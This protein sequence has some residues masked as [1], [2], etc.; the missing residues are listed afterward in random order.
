MIYTFYADCH[1]GM[2]NAKCKKELPNLTREKVLAT[3]AYYLGDN[4]DLH[5]CKESDLS[6]L[7]QKLLA[8]KVVFKGRYVS[9]NH[10]CQGVSSDYYIFLNDIVFMHGDIAEWGEKRAFEFRNKPIAVK[11]SIWKKLSYFFNG[12][13]SQ[14]Q[15]NGMVDIAKRNNC[16][17]VVAG[18]AHPSKVF[19]KMIDGVRIIVV[20]RGKTEIEI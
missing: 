7:S 20:K 13:V 11:S 17:V 18:H 3:N 14:E 1:I 6:E 16:K 4:Y 8:S 15:I 12:K 19:D 9:G 2:W 5:Y 10:C